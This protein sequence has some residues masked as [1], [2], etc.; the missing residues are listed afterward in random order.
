MHAL[1]CVVLYTLLLAV[2]IQVLLAVGGM[3]SIYQEQGLL[4]GVTDIV[5]AY[6]ISSGTK[7]FK[8]IK[9]VTFITI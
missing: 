1:I 7:S 6:C 2:M 8:S 9:D 3:M 4:V 5:F